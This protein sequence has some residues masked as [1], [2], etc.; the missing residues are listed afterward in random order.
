MER[1]PDAS[2]VEEMPD[3]MELAPPCPDSELAPPAISMDPPP[4]ATFS[5][6]NT[7]PS[8]RTCP[9]FSNRNYVPSG[10]TLL[11]EEEKPEDTRLNE[12]SEEERPLCIFETCFRS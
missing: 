1:L 8:S 9:L 12:A 7:L 3:R 10:A 4:K 11:E 5:C 6:S 2:F